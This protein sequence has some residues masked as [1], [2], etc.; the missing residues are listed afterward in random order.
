MPPGLKQTCI[1]RAPC[2]DLPVAR[3][4]HFADVKRDIDQILAD[5]VAFVCFEENPDAY[6][7]PDF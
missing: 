5:E 4:M 7:V 6:D 2:L 1:L 3:V